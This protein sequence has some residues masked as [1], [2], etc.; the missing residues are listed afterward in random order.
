MKTEVLFISSYVIT[1]ATETAAALLFRIKSARDLT[2]VLAANTLTNPL[3]N[4]LYMLAVLKLGIV[5][6][7]PLL[8]A[9]EAAV[10][11]CEALIYRK[12]IPTLERPFA[13]SFAAN[14]A[15]FLMGIFIG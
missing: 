15:S 2:V 7:R 11:I 9:M 6:A 13:F 4:L 12:L 3:I 1:I 10:V 8:F 14:M 5:G